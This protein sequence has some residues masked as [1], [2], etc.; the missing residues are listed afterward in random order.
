MATFCVAGDV[1]VDSGLS[2]AYPPSVVDRMRF[3]LRHSSSQVRVDELTGM[4]VLSTS[5]D[6]ASLCPY[7]EFCRI[8]VD[9]VVRPSDVFQVS[10]VNLSMIQQTTSDL[11]QTTC[12][13]LA[14][15]T[16]LLTLNW[17]LMETTPSHY[18]FTFGGRQSLLP[19]RPKPSGFDGDISSLSL[20]D[21]RPCFKL[22]FT[23][24]TSIVLWVET[25]RILLLSDILN[26]CRAVEQNG[27]EHETDLKFVICY[28]QL[29]QH[30]LQVYF[31]TLITE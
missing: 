15:K 18:F 1:K 10:R 22:W 6:R 13:F 3:R 30:F 28:M 8:V 2:G 26:I 31:Q 16:T 25:L 17:G 11:P 14:V 21:L 4:L 19:L 12:V 9:V 23:S 20:M 7:A 27:C 24:Y 5:L 29:R